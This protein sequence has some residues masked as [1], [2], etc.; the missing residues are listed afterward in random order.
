[1]NDWALIILIVHAGAT[2]FMTGLIWL[3]QLVH[4]PLMVRVGE[5]GFI[6]Y[7][8]AHMRRITFVVAPAMLIELATG[9]ALVVGGGTLTTWTGLF[10]LVL[11]W[12]STA[13]TQGPMHNR[14]ARGYDADLIRRLVVTNWLRT[15]AWSARAALVGYLLFQHAHTA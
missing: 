8:M 2:W 4:Y 6:A 12:L 1:M 3:V 10:L 9:V 15:T 7:E 13:T 14:L 11:L 5:P